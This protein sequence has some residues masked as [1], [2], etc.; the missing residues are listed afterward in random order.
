MPE[1]VS[2]QEAMARFKTARQALDK[3]FAAAGSTAE[4]V[5]IFRALQAIDDEIVVLI[6][7]EME[8]AD[9]AYAPLTE[10]LKA[11][12]ADLKALRTKIERAAAASEAAAKAA[13][14]LA[15]VVS[16]LA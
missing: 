1:S 12:I 11:A 8:D 2:N 13:T 5:E 16:F 3:A 7:R 9:A 4:M 15:R 10:T 14:A 6:F